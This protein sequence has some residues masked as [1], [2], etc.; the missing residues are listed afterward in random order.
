MKQ[1][2]SDYNFKP[3][4]QDTLDEIDF[5]EP[6]QIQRAIIPLLNKK[7]NVVGIS[8]TGSG[9]THAFLLPILNN[10]K[11]K[12]KLLQ[13]IIIAPTRELATQI[14]DNL[15]V[16]SQKMPNLQVSLAVGGK[17]SNPSQLVKAQIIIGTPGRMT[18]LL[19]GDKPLNISKVA[20]VV[21]DEADMIFDLDFIKEIDQILGKI[22]TNAAFAIFSATIT[23]DMHPFLK[24]YFS[25]IKVVE[26]KEPSQ[27]IRHI[28]VANK[29][30]D[31]YLTLK[32]IISTIDP[33][34]CLIF[35]SKK[36]DVST[37]AERLTK[38]GIKCIQLHGDLQP[39][40][41]ART[42]KRINNLEFNYVVASD[43]AA[44]GLDIEGVSHVISIDLPGEI[45]YYIHRAGR[46][47]RYRYEGISY[48]IY[49]VS[50]EPKIA[51]LEAKGITFEY[52]EYHDHQLVPAGYRK[53]SQKKNKSDAYSQQAINKVAR[54]K[55]SVKPGYKKKR[56]IALDKIKKKEKQKEIK[57]RIKKQ[58][59]Q[60]K[61]TKRT[62]K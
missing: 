38:D 30:H 16:F 41:R 2:F 39:R 29:Q 55:Q 7:E 9:K 1:K 45:E 57:E 15:K 35:A 48:V 37:Y 58:R 56:K 43:I 10:I 20:Y 21:I 23:P 59:K 62:D 19:K 46:T 53:R 33:Y 34:I 51:K 50:D 25:G 52:Q 28:L 11:Q 32:N 27:Q 36:S 40:E 8:R 6:T 24:K 60:R 3:S 17:E 31:R 22:K 42:L 14:Y 18:S 4:I 12:E 44:R 49:D 61:N 26:I 47:G 5:Y 13:A 54:K